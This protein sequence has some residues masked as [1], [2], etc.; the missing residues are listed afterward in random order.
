MAAT[1]LYK[2][3]LPMNQQDDMTV[4][5][6]QDGPMVPQDTRR[7][8]HVSVGKHFDLSI[9]LSVSPTFLVMLGTTV[10]VLGGNYWFLR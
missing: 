8:L 6:D 4:N 1:P 10:G 5:G 9:A 3:G 2:G 7:H